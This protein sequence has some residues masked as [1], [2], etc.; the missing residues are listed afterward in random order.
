MGH[1]SGRVLNQGLGFPFSLLPV[2][3]QCVCLVTDRGRDL[4]RPFVG[5]T[6]ST[7]CVMALVEKRARSP[8][9]DNE[10]ALIETKKSKSDALSVGAVPRTSTL[11]SPIMVLTGHGGEVRAEN[12]HAATAMEADRA[13][14]VKML[15]Q[16]WRHCTCLALCCVHSRAAAAAA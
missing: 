14:A 9:G 16:G 5:L 1:R 12:P 3:I 6:E 11:H 2:C 13:P 7:R 10:G 15:A 8:T 4:V